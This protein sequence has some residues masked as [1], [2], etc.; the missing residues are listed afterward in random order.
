MTISPCECIAFADHRRVASG[1]L[2]EVARQVKALC[3]ASP[4]TNVLVFDATTSAPIEIDCHGSVE[5]MLERLALSYA[6]PTPDA[7]PGRCGPGRPRLGVVAREVTLL[8]RHWE[9]LASQPGGASVA[10]RRLVEQARRLN[11]AGDRRYAAQEAAFRF[12]SAIA[13][14]FGGYEEATRA[15]FAADPQRFDTLT[16]DWPHDVREHLRR[17]AADAFHAASAEETR[18]A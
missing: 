12:M 6:A 8:P 7:D 17:L 3:D 16:A 15:L 11:L 1:P 10:L 13:G 5:Q 2:A 14:D 18:N 9:W 4:L